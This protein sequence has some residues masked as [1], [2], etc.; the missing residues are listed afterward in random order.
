MADKKNV[1][2][3]RVLCF[4]DRTLEVTRACTAFWADHF[5]DNSK[6]RRKVLF[7]ITIKFESSDK[8][9]HPENDF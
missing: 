6:R 3:V 4:S 1:K 2:E 5:R 9:L 7:D 8:S